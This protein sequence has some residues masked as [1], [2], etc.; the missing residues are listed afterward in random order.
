VEHA[1]GS[2]P[3]SGLPVTKW[4]KSSFSNPSGNCVEM[5]RLPDRRVAIRDSRFPDGPALI[6]TP[7][8]WLPFL[9][10]V[11]AGRVSDLL[12]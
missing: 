7:A 2:M 5:G 11:R 12:R 3:A 9:A 1:H 10:A 6:F 4:R 8:E